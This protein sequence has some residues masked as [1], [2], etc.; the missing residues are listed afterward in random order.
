MKID[1]D[2]AVS[3][4]LT[5]TESTGKVIQSGKTP[6]AYLHGGYDNVFPKLEAA[7]QAGGAADVAATQ[8]LIFNARLDA[9]ICGIFMVLVAVILLDSIRVWSGILSGNGDRRVHEAPFVVSRLQ[10]EEL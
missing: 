9:A 3:L 10:A 2:T 6:V 1:K 7:L 5:I 8:T 4:R